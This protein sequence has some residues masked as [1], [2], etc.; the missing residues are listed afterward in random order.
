M[1]KLIVILLVLFLYGTVPAS[2]PTDNDV[3][4][5]CKID[6]QKVQS[7]PVVLH[8]VENGIVEDSELRV[9]NFKAD[10]FIVL[11][12]PDEE[13]KQTASGYRTKHNEP[14]NFSI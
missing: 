9:T 7:N 3:G 12:Y 2:P 4:K 5:I 8:S 1:K 13:I 6:A 10:N 11:S 14:P